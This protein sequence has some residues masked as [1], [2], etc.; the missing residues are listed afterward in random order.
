MTPTLFIGVA[1]SLLVTELTGYS[2]G[3][4]IVAGYL[5]LFLFQPLWLAGTL[6][7]ALLTFAAVR[8]FENRLLLYGRRQFAVYLLAGMLVSQL[9]M[10]LTLGHALGDVVLLVVGYL[11]PGLIA[12]DLSRQGVV[13]TMLVTALTVLIT[14]M[15][16]LVGEGLLW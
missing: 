3:G 13:V 16:L 6:T 4:V 8:L 10:R 2:P 12:R 9:L 14:Q 5:S 1:V 11:V 7:A 15:A